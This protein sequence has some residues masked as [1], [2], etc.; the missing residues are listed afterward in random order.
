MREVFFAVFSR[1]RS[2]YETRGEDPQ[3]D[4]RTATSLPRRKTVII[5][6]VFVVV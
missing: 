6:L 4:S 1:K 2:R 5:I 3:G